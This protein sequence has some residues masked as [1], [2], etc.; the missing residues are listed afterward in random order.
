MKSFSERCG[1]V[2]ER[3]LQSECM[4]QRLRNRLSNC[5][6]EFIPLKD[7]YMGFE[8]IIDPD[9]AHFFIDE[10]G[11]KWKGHPKDVESVIDQVAERGEWHEVYTMVERFAYSL[12]EDDIKPFAETLATLLEEEKAGYKTL[13]VGDDDKRCLIVGIT[14]ELEIEEIE[15]ACSTNY[16][17]VNSHIEAAVKLFSERTSP[18][19]PNAVKEA[20][21]AVE[22]A[23][24]IVDGKAKTLGD[25][26]KR[27][28][29]GSSAMNARLLGGLE[30][31]YAYSSETVRHGSGEPVEVSQA[32]A[33]M[34]IV[35]CSA[36]ANYVL[37]DCVE[38]A[39]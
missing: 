22:S 20:I 18:D 8:Q 26:I 14:N 39:E 12:E 33:K 3:V 17:A 6:Y 29:K 34:M 4:D 11:L 9:F 1:Y 28:R 31:L 13:V 30:K 32:E 27:T 23:L 15:N 10:M 37:A 5:L 24:C 19:Y 35:L 36:I 7:D 16:D 2:P 21:S 38:H 25:A